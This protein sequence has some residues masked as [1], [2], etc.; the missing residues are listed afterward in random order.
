ME[1]MEGLRELGRRDCI[2][3][4]SA[5]STIPFTSR[6]KKWEDGPGSQEKGCSRQKLSPPPEGLS[7][8]DLHKSHN[9]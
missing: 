4:T 1:D 3:E 8:G 6:T 9:E 2:S 5:E 7:R